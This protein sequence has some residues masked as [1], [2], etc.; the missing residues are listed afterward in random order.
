MALAITVSGLAQEVSKPTSSFTVN[1]KVK[2][3]KTFTMADLKKLSPH[4]IGDIVIINHR[5]EARG[6]AK[7][8]TGVLLTQVLEQVEL[9]AET[10]R[11]LSEYYFAC[12]AA[13]GYRVVYS[14]NELFNTV[15]GNSVYIIISKD[16]KPIDDADENVLMIS[17][18]DAKTGRRYLKNLETILVGRI[19]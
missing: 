9:D 1:G 8:L 15:V 13:D 5:G 4:N 10:P 2:S 16:H 17:T 3:P 7:E 18:Q 19:R 12:I 6:T 11:V 14:W